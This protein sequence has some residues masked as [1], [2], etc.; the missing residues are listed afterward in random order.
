M[1]NFLLVFILCLFCTSCGVKS[2]PKY[3]VQQHKNK[4]I[5]KL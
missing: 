2:D 3:E 5:N 4:T 1:K